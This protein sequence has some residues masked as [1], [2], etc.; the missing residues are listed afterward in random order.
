MNSEPLCFYGGKEQPTARLIHTN[1][2]HS[3]TPHFLP[4]LATPPEILGPLFNSVAET[5]RVRHV[6]G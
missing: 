6:R 5:R 2:R 4:P 1:E 3:P